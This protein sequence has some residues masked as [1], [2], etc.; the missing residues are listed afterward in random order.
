MEKP[1][2]AKVARKLVADSEARKKNRVAQLDRKAAY[3]RR[4][5]RAA[6]AALQ[7]T[8]AHAVDAAASKR[9]KVILGLDE[10]FTKLEDDAFVVLMS[11]LRALG[12]SC[13]T[14]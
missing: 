12:F 11:K 7:T 13:F 5:D 4:L 2:L 14:R 10:L 6:N 9:H 3:K 8:L 1:I